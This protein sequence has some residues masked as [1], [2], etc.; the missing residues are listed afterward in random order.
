MTDFLGGF[1]TELSKNLADKWVSLLALPGALYLA[2]FV[3]GRALGQFHALDVS[4]LVRRIT[5]WA[6]DPAATTAGGQIVLLAAVLA[7]SVATGLAARFLG[8]AIERVALAADWRS[9]PRPARDLARRRTQKRRNR[10]DEAH[11]EYS[12]WWEE[13]ART[14]A[15]NRP[16][17]P[18]PR[19]AALRT[20]AAISAERPDR[21]TWS[22]DRMHA[23]SVRLRRDHRLD[24]TQVWPHMWLMLPDE[25]RNEIT[26]TRTAIARATELG[27]WAALY[28][29]LAFVWWPAGIVGL[30]LGAAACRRT[31]DATD[32]YARLVEAAVRLH[33]RELAQRLGIDPAG[34]L[35]SHVGDRFSELLGSAPPIVPDA[36]SESG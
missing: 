4:L 21:P 10:W 28:T 3:A 1:G 35:S 23:V 19:H 33:V 26:A 16:H 36:R 17:D 14:Q 8:A 5:S 24:L 11:R 7:A 30:S 13:G 34:P 2:V 15:L 9:W 27:A 29:L 12:L 31:R 32:G 25:A 18:G 22:G 20:R 6:D